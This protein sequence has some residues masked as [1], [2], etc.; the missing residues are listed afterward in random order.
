MTTKPQ[1]T[2]CPTVAAMTAAGSFNLA[3]LAEH[4]KDCPI[5]R[6]IVQAL[7]PIAR[8]A[9]TPWPV[10]PGARFW[11]VELAIDADDN[12]AAD[13]LSVSEHDE[14]HHDYDPAPIHGQDRLIV[15]ATAP[16]YAAAIEEARRQA[17]THPAR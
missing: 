12:P 1:L 2:I 9:V 4:V 13:V 5:C 14:A 8:E 6:P 11:R 17:R 7:L 15:Y 10:D 16:N 3:D